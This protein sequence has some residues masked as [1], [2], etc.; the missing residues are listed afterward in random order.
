MSVH[1]LLN[2]LNVL[3]KSDKMRG[4]PSMLSLFRNEFNK[5]NNTRAGMLDSIYHMTINLLKNHIFG[6]KTSRFCHLLRNI[7]MDVITSR[8]KICK[9][10]VVYRFL[11]MVLYHSQMRRHVI[12]LHNLF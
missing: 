1:V 7:I 6:V 10:L 8:Y 3:R 5:F 4:L 9:P 12:W 11:Y 2:L